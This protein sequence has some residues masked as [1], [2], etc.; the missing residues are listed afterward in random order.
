MNVNQDI[1]NKVEG[2]IATKK[3]PEKVFNN[4]PPKKEVPDTNTHQNNEDLIQGWNTHFNQS[5]HRVFHGGRE[6]KKAGV[7]G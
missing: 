2:M 5:K 7:M 6:E 3:K 1:L 4:N